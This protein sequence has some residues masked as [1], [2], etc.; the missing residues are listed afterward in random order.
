MQKR[1]TGSECSAYSIKRNK[2]DGCEILDPDSETDSP[3]HTHCG[4]INIKMTC[5]LN[6]TLQALFHVPAFSEFVLSEEHEKKCLHSSCLRCALRVTLTSMVS[7]TESA[8][9]PSLV[10]AILPDFWEEFI[11]GE[12]QDAHELLIKFLCVLGKQVSST[13]E[14]SSIFGGVLDRRGVFQC[15]S[16]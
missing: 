9:S 5:F 3:R 2:S 15:I 4:L 7:S 14:L 16:R 10:L 13:E 8:I 1:P 11:L 6:A 12:Q